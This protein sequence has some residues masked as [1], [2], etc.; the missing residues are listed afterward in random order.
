[1]FFGVRKKE[2]VSAFDKSVASPCALLGTEVALGYSTAA[3][4]D[5]PEVLLC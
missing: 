2:S 5:P 1:M 4:D 3:Q